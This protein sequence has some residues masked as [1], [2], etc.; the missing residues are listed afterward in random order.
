MNEAFAKA[1]EEIQA[2]MRPLQEQIKPVLDQID[3]KKK[4]VNQL[5]HAAGAEPFYPEVDSEKAATIGLGPILPDQYFGK[6]V[7]TV[8][9]DILERRKRAGLSAIPL[10]DLYEAMK[11]GG[12]EFD[13]KDPEIARRNV[14]ITL[15]KNTQTFTRVPSTGSWGL[16]EWYPNAG[17]RNKTIASVSTQ[18]SPVTSPAPASAD[19]IEVEFAD[20]TTPTNPNP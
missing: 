2:Q 8:V 6:P 11:A 18:D 7:A 12:F 14:A 17:K 10:A 20:E 3:S 19:T 4:L 9:R 15:G 1:I 16:A 13:N 5:C